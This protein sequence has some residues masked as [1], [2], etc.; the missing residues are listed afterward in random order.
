ML[1][2][3]ES[4]GGVV[5]QDIHSFDQFV[6]RYY[7]RVIK[8]ND[9]GY[10]DESKSVGKSTGVKAVS[11]G[12]NKVKLTWDSTEGAEGYLIYAQKNRTYAYCGMTQKV[13]RS[14]I[15]KR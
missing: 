7:G 14:Q 4:R 13:R 5:V 2:A 9:A 10:L 12:K 6:I 3:S 15:Q 8:E 11:A 1:E